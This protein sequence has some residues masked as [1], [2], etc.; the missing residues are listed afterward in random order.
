MAIK[1]DVGLNKLVVPLAARSSPPIFIDVVHTGV[2]AFT[3]SG[4]FVTPPINR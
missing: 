2:D 4:C 3:S 1:V